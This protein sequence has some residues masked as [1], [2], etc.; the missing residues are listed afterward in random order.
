[1]TTQATIL[2]SGVGVALHRILSAWREVESERSGNSQNWAPPHRR[3][4][5]AVGVFLT[6]LIVA[7][8]TQICDAAPLGR[9]LLPTRGVYVQVFDNGLQSGDYTGTYIG[10]CNNSAWPCD[11]PTEPNEVPDQLDQ[12][13]A[14]GVNT[15]TIEIAATD[16]ASDSA[17]NTTFP[18]CNV[19]PVLGFFWPQPTSGQLTNLVSF[20]D[21]VQSK[22]MKVFLRLITT[23]MEDQPPTGSQQWIGAILNAVKNH[24]AL[25]LVLFEGSTRGSS[26][27]CYK[28]PSEC[29]IAAEPPLFSGVHSVAAKYIQWAIGYAMSLGVSVNKLSAEEIAGSYFLERQGKTCPG[30]PDGGHL[31]SPITV[32]QQIFSNLNVPA[33]EQTYALSI[34]E[35]NKC[36]GANRLPCTDTDLYR[37]T[38]MTLASI[39]KRV[40]YS[41][42]VV[43]AEMGAGYP[44]SQLPTERAVENLIV[45]FQKYE[46]DGGSFYEW[47]SGD[48]NHPTVADTI[49]LRGSVTYEPVEK[50]IVDLGGFHLTSISNGSFE[51][52]AKQ[53]APADWTI[54][55]SGTGKRYF[56]AR[57][58]KEPQ[59]L[60]RGR[61]SLRLVTGRGASDTV[62]ATSV[63]IA[64]SPN[65]FY[66]TTG[67]LRF[68]WTGDLNP[69]G[70]PNLRPQVFVKIQYFQPSGEPS[71]VRLENQFSYFQEDSTGDFKTFPLQYTTPADAAAVRI[72]LGAARNG[73]PSPIIFDADNL[74]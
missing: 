62:S 64:V 30:G 11:Q 46:V 41:S 2:A 71:A 53:G 66:T 74:R 55:G 70:P 4:I 35:H 42:R 28:P 18:S 1:M 38:D 6:A 72:Q 13:A 73:L 37:W 10:G 31:W 33:N 45:L 57:E 20:F 52:A 7:A 61:Y 51:K 34:Y 22:G 36:F 27:A 59:V 49:K 29:S 26:T 68:N 23:H 3:V 5:R 39:R 8:S 19:C 24:P 17:C 16:Q 69:S 40:G 25:D 15:I 65:T 9:Y 12:M 43:A 50:E 58:R 47:T 60:T 44:S 63:L 32:M 21:V 67:N 56:L 48:I 14:M 54:A